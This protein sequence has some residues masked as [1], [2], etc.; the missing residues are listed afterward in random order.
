[1][2]YFNF[3]LKKGEGLDLEGIL[4]RLEESKNLS[5]DAN[6]YGDSKGVGITAAKR[7]ADYLGPE[8]VKGKNICLYY[9]ISAY[10]PK[11]T[12]TERAIPT[13]IFFADN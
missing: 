7:L 8:V 2:S 6:E 11:K 1:M 9:I 10:P 12:V 5:K 4:E 3:I 13:Q